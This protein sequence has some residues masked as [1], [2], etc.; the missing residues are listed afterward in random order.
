MSSGTDDFHSDPSHVTGDPIVVNALE[1]PR[2]GIEV[3][4]LG[5][6]LLPS[7]GEPA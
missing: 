7:H 5:Y 6:P 2:E 1:I 3:R 4:G